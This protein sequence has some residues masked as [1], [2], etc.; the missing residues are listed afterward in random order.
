MNPQIVSAIITGLISI[1]VGAF[2]G[3]W[4]QRKK[5]ASDIEIALRADRLSEYRKLW[6]LTETLGWYGNNELTS[7]KVNTLLANL[8]HWYYD[9]GAGILLSE[10]SISEFEKLLFVL[11]NFDGRTEQVKKQGTR[12]RAA[13]VLPLTLS[14]QLSLTLFPQIFNTYPM[15]AAPFPG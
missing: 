10:V 15:K 13:L 12:L 4:I 7:E 14:N 6:S 11:H 1:P 5:L 3:A 9:N 8:D 2:V